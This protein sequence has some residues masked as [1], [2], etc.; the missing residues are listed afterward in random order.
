MEAPFKIPLWTEFI[1]KSHWADG[2][3]KE[4]DVTLKA[5]AAKSDPQ[6]NNM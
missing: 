3:R 2:T 4:T 6:I 1:R 5:T